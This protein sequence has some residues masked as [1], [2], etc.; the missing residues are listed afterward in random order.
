MWRLRLTTARVRDLRRRAYS[1]KA[2]GRDER[3]DIATL[4][5]AASSRDWQ[6]PCPKCGRMG[7]AASPTS[8]ILPPA[9]RRRRPRS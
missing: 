3:S 7:C 6:P 8:T 9:T 5:T 1:R 4:S 2:L